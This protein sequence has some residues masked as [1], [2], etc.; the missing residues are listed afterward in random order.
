[1]GFTAA[2]LLAMPVAVEGIEQLPLVPVTWNITPRAG[3]IGVLRNPTL[4][5]AGRVSA[6]RHGTIGTNVDGV[7]PSAA[8]A[9]WVT[10]IP[11]ASADAIATA[12]NA[13]QVARCMMGLPRDARESNRSVIVHLRH[14]RRFHATVRRRRLLSLSTHAVRFAVGIRASSDVRV[15]LDR[16]SGRSFAACRTTSLQTL[17]WTRV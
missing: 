9:K 7:D 6:S 1:M 16:G 11:V 5:S 8:S 14:S 17:A 12:N 10:T 15:V 3:P 2:M 13:V 4:S